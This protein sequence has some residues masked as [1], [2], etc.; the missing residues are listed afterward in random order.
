MAKKILMVCDSLGGGGAERQLTLMATSLVDPWQVSVFALE[1]GVFEDEMQAAGVPLNISPRKF[2]LDPSPISALYGEIA[3]LRPD[4]VHSWGW[5]TS[6]AAELC[7]RRWRIPHV[8]GVIRRAMLP[9]SRAWTLKRASSLGTVVVANSQAGLDVFGV[10]PERGRVLYNGFAPERLAR[11]DFDRTD[12]P[13]DPSGRFKVVMAATMDN[14][15]DFP[16]LIDSARQLLD[17]GR[18]DAG[19]TLL[20]SGS[21][22]DALVNSAADLIETGH[23]EFPGRVHE[24]MDYYESTDVGVMLSTPIH[25]EGLS[26]S[27][28]EFMASSLPVVCT[29][30]GGNRELVVDGVTGFLIPPSNAAALTGKLIWLEENRDRARA[31]GRAGRKRIEDEFGVARMVERAAEIY[32]E[33]M[34]GN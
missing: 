22:H 6:F 33:V 9:H 1:G 25:G 27:I 23:M 15:K 13:V 4:V 18:I 26:N 2:R 28:M 17:G 8:S 3:R 14:R 12:A 31:M 10:P 7:C 20:G 30:Q 34:G 19:F 11:A 21:D 32:T 24:V 5:M 29:D 16:L